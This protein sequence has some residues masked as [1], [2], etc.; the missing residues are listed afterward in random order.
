MTYRVLHV[1]SE[2]AV[3][4]AACR[5]SKTTPAEILSV[6]YDGERQARSGRR[7]SESIAGATR[8]LSLKRWHNT[9]TLCKRRRSPVPMVVSTLPSSRPTWRSPLGRLGSATAALRGG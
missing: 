6:H 2:V 4:V 8:G 5:T 9:G 1:A 3:V 7:Q